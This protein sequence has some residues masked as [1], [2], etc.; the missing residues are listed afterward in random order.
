MPRWCGKSP[1]PT[2]VGAGFVSPTRSNCW[3]SSSPPPLNRRHTDF[4][5]PC[6]AHQSTQRAGSVLGHRQRPLTVL[7]IGVLVASGS[8][9]S[10]IPSVRWP[11]GEA[12][13]SPPS[14][15]RMIQPSCQR[16]LD[17]S[18]RRYCHCHCRL[19]L[20]DSNSQE[21]TPVIIIATHLR[22]DRLPANSAAA[23]RS[24]RR[25]TGTSGIDENTCSL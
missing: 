5:V 1:R 20:L 12:F 9:N 19:S 13:M 22:I 10:L 7:Q 17:H 23:R 21:E 24:H 6:S 18:R 15:C 14:C 8:A 3:A 11:S 2:S 16:Q 4:S 25:L